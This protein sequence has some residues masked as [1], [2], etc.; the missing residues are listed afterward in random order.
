MGCNSTP[1]R[2]ITI[3][4][5]SQAV[6]KGKYTVHDDANAGTNRATWPE[7]FRYWLAD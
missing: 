4:I 1:V 7:G 5:D 3:L 6:M 2:K